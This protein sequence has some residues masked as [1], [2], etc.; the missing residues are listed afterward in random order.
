MNKLNN[1][2]ILPIY[3]DGH[4][5]LREKCE[6]IHRDHIGLKDIIEKMHATLD[7]TKIGVGLAAS[8]VGMPIRLFILGGANEN[9]PMKRRVFINPKIILFKGAR[10]KDF[11]S[12]LSVP[13]I[14]ARVERY[15]KIRVRYRDI[16][17]NEHVEGFKNFEARVIQHEYD[18]LNGI[19]FYDRISKVEYERI[20]GRIEDL[21]GGELPSLEYEVKHQ[22]R[23]ND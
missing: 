18:H 1:T 4:P 11:E 13:K 17:F 8:Q 15:Q 20:I 7:K 23:T 22:T 3:I 21:R 10:R 14:S 12:C 9:S 19:Q 16:D 6:M 5:V 2:K